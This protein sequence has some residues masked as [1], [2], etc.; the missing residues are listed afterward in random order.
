MESSL[1]TTV[2]LAVLMTCGPSAHA[3]DLLVFA[4]TYTTGASRGIYA[5]RFQTADG[6][7]RPLGV[8]VETASP[9]FLALHPN[10][11]FLYA[12]NED[13]K[14]VSAFAIDGKTGKLAFLN[15]VPSGG[16]G[17]CHLALDATGRWLAVANFKSG[18]M[19]LL[20]VHADGRLGEVTV[21]EKHEGSRQP[22][23][24]Q[25]VFSPDN[26]FLLLADLGLDRIFVYRFD[27]ATGSLAANDPPSARVAAGAGVRHLAFHPNGKVLYAVNEIDSTVTAF[28]YDAAKGTLDSFQTV[29]AL[30]AGYKGANTAAEIAVNA[31]GTVVYV[32]NRGHDSIVLFS[33]DPERFTLLPMDHA[34]T[35]GATPRHFAIDPAGT[36]LLSANQGSDEIAVFRVHP[37]TGQLTPLGRPV[38]GAPSP[39][40][41]LFVPE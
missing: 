39:V 33:I 25:A 28:L 26:R 7:L 30:P 22:H 8:A 12:V 9:S 36:Y 5:F 3:A 17:P 1:K 32:S 23:A 29:P 13:A 18:T 31:A 14:A 27:A 35:L 21:V 10:R 38:K 4:G 2:A 41:V 24:H 16:E 6:R 15:A 20:P 34:P 11:R 19:A 37:N 40:C